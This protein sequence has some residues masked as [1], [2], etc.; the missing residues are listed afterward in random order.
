MESIRDFDSMRGD[1]QDDE[2]FFCEIISTGQSDIWDFYA[3]IKF[4]ARREEVEE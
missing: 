2:E 3:G 1:S 4:I